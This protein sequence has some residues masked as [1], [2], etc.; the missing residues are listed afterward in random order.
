LRISPPEALSQAHH[1]LQEDLQD[2]E[3]AAALEEVPARM[4]ARLEALRQHLTEH[5]RFEEKDGY[6][7]AVRQ[8]EPNRQ[9]ETDQLLEEHR[10]LAQSLDTLLGEARGAGPLRDTFG[11]NVR[12]WVERVRQHE[13]HENRLVQEV[14]NRDTSAED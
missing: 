5:F 6:L 11:E 9:R 1:A 7:D 10:L 14:F 13:A 12:A 3:Q 2:L 4:A 8:R